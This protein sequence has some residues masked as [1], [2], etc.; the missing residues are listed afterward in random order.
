MM[1]LGARAF[2][3]RPIRLHDQEDE[4]DW[5]RERRRRDRKK[6]LGKH[7]KEDF[8]RAKHSRRRSWDEDWDEEL[9]RR[10]R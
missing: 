1:S 8:D 7:D 5:E 6:K 2:I 10:R 3:P 9:P 4:K